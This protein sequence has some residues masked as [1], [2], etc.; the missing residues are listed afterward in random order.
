M[1][2]NNLKEDI[3][4]VLDS[5][6][7][8]AEI[9][10]VLKAPEGHQI[11]MADL[12]QIS[13]TEI[14]EQCKDS[15]R[16][17]LLNEELSLLN[18]SESDSRSDVVYKYDLAEVPKKL[19][20]LKQVSDSDDFEDFKFDNDNLSDLEGILIVIGNHEKQLVIYKYQYPIYLL[21]RKGFS[22][23][24][25][26]NQSRFEK[27]DEE[28]LKINPTF[29]FLYINN[30]YY[31]FD[32]KL[33]ERVFGFHQAIMN[34]ARAGIN[35]I[36]AANLVDDINHL[37][38]RL[39]NI[40]FAKKLLRAT[41]NSP[42]LGIISLENIISFADSHPLLKKK[43]KVNAAGTRLDL[44]TKVSQNLFMK[45]LNDDLLQSELTKMFYDSVSKDKVEEISEAVAS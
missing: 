11:K 4:A 7:V 3:T 2:I 20:C 39:D 35:V 27:L 8:S 38:N 41:K 28:V 5:K 25:I 13:H 43:L 29:E 32:L 19:G 37:I 36:A 18:I 40:R 30:D 15:I 10:F 1:T 9:Y 22:L 21:N 16:S 14:F 33:L 34:D 42:V 24:R 44:R 45:L 17:I 26:K 31:V 23:K 12:D 6:A